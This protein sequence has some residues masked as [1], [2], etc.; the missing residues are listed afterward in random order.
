MLMKINVFGKIIEVNRNDNRWEVF[1]VGNEGKKRLANDIVIPSHLKKEELIEYFSDL[2]HE[3]AT[4]VNNEV[5]VLD[6]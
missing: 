1:Y 5:K 6:Q 2:C 4:P 3:W